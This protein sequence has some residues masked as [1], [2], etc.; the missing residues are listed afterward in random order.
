MN[1]PLQFNVIHGPNNLIG[2]SVYNLYGHKDLAHPVLKKILQTKFVKNSFYSSY[3]GSICKRSYLQRLQLYHLTLLKKF[4]KQVNKQRLCNRGRHICI[5][6]QYATNQVKC[7]KDNKLLLFI[8]IIFVCFKILHE[9]K[10]KNIP[11]CVCLLLRLGL[12]QNKVNT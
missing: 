5:D 10:P 3:C 11:L 1:R 12:K 9:K 2:F 7:N 4:N 8:I 6:I